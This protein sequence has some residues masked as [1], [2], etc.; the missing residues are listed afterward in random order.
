MAGLS[1]MTDPVFARLESQYQDIM[2]LQ[3]DVDAGSD[4]IQRRDLASFRHLLR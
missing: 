4:I 2:F 3:V 1:R